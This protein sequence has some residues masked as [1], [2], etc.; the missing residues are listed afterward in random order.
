MRSGNIIKWTNKFS[1]DTGYVESVSFKDKHINSTPDI[2][3]AKS[4]SSFKVAAGIISK[5][6]NNDVDQQNNYEVL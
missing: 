1:G 5:L 3:K 6:R 4:Y 2:T